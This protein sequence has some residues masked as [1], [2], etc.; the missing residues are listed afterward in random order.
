[1]LKLG[2]T[3]KKPDLA[4]LTVRVY[5]LC[6]R[7]KVILTLNLQ[8]SLAGEVVALPDDAGVPPAV[9]GLGVLHDQGEHVVVV[10][11]GELGPLVALLHTHHGYNPDKVGV[12]DHALAKPSK[13]KGFT[14]EQNTFWKF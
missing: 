3:W 6:C 2:N 9:P 13:G 8:V 5:N 14:L 4:A 11:E 7:Y 12:R 10:D 1:M